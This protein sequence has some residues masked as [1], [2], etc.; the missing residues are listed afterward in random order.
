MSV[1]GVP[2]L[3][4]CGYDT[5]VS[6]AP[7]LVGCGYDTSVSVVPCWSAPTTT[8]HKATTQPK[9]VNKTKSFESDHEIMQ[10]GTICLNLVEDM[11]ALQQSWA[12]P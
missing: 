11:W 9:F 12:E 1:S 6:V 4:G 7:L 10:N 2:L 3:V 5:S 8:Q